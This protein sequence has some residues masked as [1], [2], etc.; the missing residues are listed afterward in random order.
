MSAGYVSETVLYSSGRYAWT[1][2][3]VRKP[4]GAS[5]AGGDGNISVP[6]KGTIVKI[7]V[8]EGDK[9][10]AGDILVVLE[11][12]K[13]ENNIASDVNGT[14]A[15]ITIEEGDSVGAGDIIILIDLED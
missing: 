15:E 4:V 13:M 10:E 14:I 12:M 8:A 9:V 6:M 3:G 1:T 5:A 7:Q 2:S 11:A